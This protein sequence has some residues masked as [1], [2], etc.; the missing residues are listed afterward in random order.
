MVYSSFGLASAMVIFSR[1]LP[2]V[3]NQY[4]QC[5]GHRYCIY[6]VYIDTVAEN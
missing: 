4:M 5:D 6:P 3:I 2:V 1:E